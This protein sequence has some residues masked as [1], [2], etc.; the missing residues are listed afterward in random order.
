MP[1][2]IIQG[3]DIANLINKITD[4][5]MAVRADIRADLF[6]Q[7]IY[8]KGY[9][10]TWEQGMFCSCLDDHSGQ[11]DYG[12]PSCKGKG[13]VYF[14]PNEIRA[15]VTSISGSKDQN[16][17]VGMDEIGTAYLTPMSTDKIGFRDRFTFL[18]F[19]IKFSEIIRGKNTRR[20]MLR[21]P[22]IK[23]LSVRILDVEYLEGVHYNMSKDGWFVEWVEMPDYGDLT[24]SVLYTTNP[25][26]IA[27]GPI[28]E[29]R[30]TY[31]LR[32]GKGHEVFTKLPD[33]YQIKRE[34]FLVNEDVG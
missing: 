5:P 34:D 32:Q 1:K 27:I 14:N 8:Q 10:I 3:E 9:R 26:Y 33:Q 7:A 22:A 6:D 2:E 11:P 30:G 23:M 17:R 16:N 31:T 24:Y 18:D 12:C 19:T 15:L 28:H 25:V 29:L 20:H 4:S 21:Y 13:Y